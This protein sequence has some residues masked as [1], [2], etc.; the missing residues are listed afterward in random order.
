M[1]RRSKLHKPCLIIIIDPSI[2][3]T[4]QWK[5]QARKAM[6]DPTKATAKDGAPARKA[7]PVIGDG[8]GES[9]SAAKTD[10]TIN[11][12][13]TTR[14]KRRAETLFCAAPA[15]STP[16][17]SLDHNEKLCKFGDCVISK[18]LNTASVNVNQAGK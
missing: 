10:E 12:A 9:A 2:R 7:A 11:T 6:R 17:V 16:T 3:L 4:I 5:K 13:I 14:A 8:L 18:Q 15:I 1:S